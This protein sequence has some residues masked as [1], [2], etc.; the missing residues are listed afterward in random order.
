[1]HWTSRISILDTETHAA[2]ETNSGFILTIPQVLQI[3][4]QAATTRLTSRPTPSISHTTSSPG[5]R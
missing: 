4:T 2:A 3:S 5:C 1:M